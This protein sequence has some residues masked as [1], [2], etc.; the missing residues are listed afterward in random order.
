MVGGSPNGCSNPREEEGK[1]S[2]HQKRNQVETVTDSLSGVGKPQVNRV[3]GEE[4]PSATV[5][6]TIPHGLSRPC[7]EHLPH[8]SLR[9]LVGLFL[10][11]PFLWGVQGCQWDLNSVPE[12]EHQGG[13]GIR[14]H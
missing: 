13:A 1:K 11:S 8:A 4:C 7:S 3:T 9:S 2:R 14:G 10:H 5:N 12:G 6:S